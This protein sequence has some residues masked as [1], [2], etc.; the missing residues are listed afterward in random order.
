MIRK[1]LVANKYH[2]ISGGAE[3]YFLS[4]MDALKRRGVEAIPFSVRYPKTLS[5]PYEKYFIDPVIKGGEAKIQKQKPRAWESARLAARSVYNL[6]ARDAVARICREE[7]PDIL[8]LLNINNHLS[9]SVID[10]AHAFGIP[11]VMRMSDFNLVCASNMYFR[12]GK[13]CTDCKGGLHHAVIN[14]CVHGSFVKSCVSALGTAWHRRSGVY[15]KVDAF[16]TPSLFMKRDLCEQGYPPRIIHQINTFV[17]PHG[18]G[19]PNLAQP[20]ILFVGR[21]AEYKGAD[22]ALEAFA[23]VKGF[24]DVTFRLLGDEGDADA[25]RLKEKCAA[26]GNPRVEFLPFERDKAKL[27]R[28]IQ[29]SLFTLV[30]SINYENLPNT[31]LESFAC[32]RPVIST[33]FG[34]IPE[35][36]HDGENGLLYE[37]GDTADFAAKIERLLG[38][39]ELRERMG[40]NAYRDVIQNYSEDGHLNSLLGLFEAVADSKKRIP[41]AAAV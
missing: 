20:Y 14:R 19:E 29:R 34:S 33:R 6:E 21:F 2:F 9:P 10:A 35:N 17:H 4:V 31:L 36:V 23:R 12:G 5:T 22:V 1:V 26:L 7:R 38:D 28:L 27:I 30:P 3:R 41:E 11:V 13:P 16:V 25:R 18:P 24:P 37:F 32:G 39:G 15:Q 8:Y 40:R